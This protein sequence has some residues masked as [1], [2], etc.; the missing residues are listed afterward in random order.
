MKILLIR[1]SSL[2]DTVLVTAAA[3]SIKEAIGEAEIYILTKKEYSP[4]FQNNPDISGV[5]H[6]VSRKVK[7]D[8]IIDLHNN[9]R[10]RTRKFMI[11]AFKRLS[12]NK[13]SAAR[14]V[15]LH[16]G[17]MQESLDKTVI[18]RY[19]D[20]LI[21]EGYKLQKNAPVIITTTEEDLEAGK[22]LPPRPVIALVPGA[23]WKTKEWPVDKF[24]SLAVKSIKHLNAGIII[25]GG[26]EDTE[27]AERVCSGTG[28]L[29]K[30]IRNCAGETS[31]REYF[32]LIKKADAIVLPDSAA[33]HI[34]WAVKTP[35]VALYGPTVKEFGF[36]PV[37][38]K[39]IILEKEMDCRPCSL[40]GSD[41]CR[42]KDRACLQRIEV[43]E[44]FDELKRIL[45]A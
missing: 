10:S 5:I 4:V 41:K 19:I 12:Y 18:E 2:G 38:E 40:H 33:L 34:A 23:R 16:S 24:T 30:H 14:R 6:S 11:P 29:K 36:Q 7:Y 22:K 39:V 25:L 42:Y 21:R 37:D 13:V 26:T 43:D 8:F 20:P 17:L 1:Y 44:V 45:S 15:F 28:L 27:L 3:R 32:A 9:L 31:L 35:A